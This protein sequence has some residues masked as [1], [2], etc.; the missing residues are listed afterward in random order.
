MKEQKGITLVALVVTIVVLIILAG[1]SINLILGEDGIITKAKQ[2]KENM[3]L[4][5]IEEQTHLNELYAGLNSQLGTSGDIDYDAITKLAEF[6]KK[7]ADY[8]EE[9]GGI[10]PDYNAEV[11]VFGDNIKGILTE[12]TKTATATVEDITNDKTAWVNGKLLVGTN[13]NT[14]SKINCNFTNLYTLKD[15]IFQT[16]DVTN[17]NTLN[18]KLMRG[19]R[20]TDG[21]INGYTLS[22]V[23]LNELYT[24]QNA[25]T[26]PTK[27][28]IASYTISTSQT[29]YVEYS[30]DITDINYIGFQTIN[31]GGYINVQIS[32]E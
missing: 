13:A 9:A 17:Y 14:S 28:Q 32:A 4:A 25:T 19:L 3:E 16:L 6:K 8:I 29:S 11:E 20:P 15:Y 31:A 24:G 1:I 27:T 30:I 23:N 2:A 18:I 7:I 26:Q 5:Q 12:V 21:S 10:K 22:I